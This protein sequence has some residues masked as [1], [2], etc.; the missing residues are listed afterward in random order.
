M[1]RGGRVGYQH[2]AHK[3]FVDW[4]SHCAASR[5]GAGSERDGASTLT[6]RSVGVASRSALTIAPESGGARPTRPHTPSAQAI[7]TAVVSERD[8]PKSSSASAI[9]P[10]ARQRSRSGCRLVERRRLLPFC[11]RLAARVWRRLCCS[12]SPT[13]SSR[14]CSSAG[15]PSN[16]VNAAGVPSS[17]PNRCS[18]ASQKPSHIKA[19]SVPFVSKATLVATSKTIQRS[20]RAS[21]GP[22]RV[23]AASQTGRAQCSTRVLCPSKPMDPMCSHST[24]GATHSIAL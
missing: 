21:S 4:R 8:A 2:H 19:A 13:L 14:S 1:K 15:H 7:L 10:P 6:R 17:P 3:L 12:G 23:V 5:S 11:G 18:F 9:P 24:E 20:L 22:P 16:C